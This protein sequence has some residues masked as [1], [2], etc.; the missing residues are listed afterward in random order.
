M[1]TAQ[2]SL[3]RDLL[4][5]KQ[6]KAGILPVRL[7]LGRTTPEKGEAGCWG[8]SEDDHIHCLI[9]LNQK[10]HSCRLLAHR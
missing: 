10:P 8:R 9:F 2:F 3:D 6:D 1:G 5:E 7:G 4:R